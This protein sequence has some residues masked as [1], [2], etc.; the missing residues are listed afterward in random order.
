MYLD[1]TK[2]ALHMIIQKSFLTDAD[3]EEVADILKNLVNN[4]DADSETKK[5][6]MSC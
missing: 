1:R 3:S 5:N 6:G 4:T 2:W